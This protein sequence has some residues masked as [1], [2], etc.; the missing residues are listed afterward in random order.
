MNEGLWTCSW[1][2]PGTEAVSRKAQWDLVTGGMSFALLFCDDDGYVGRQSSKY[3]NEFFD[4]GVEW[5][6]MS[7]NDG[8]VAS[9]TAYALANIGKE[10]IL[11]SHSGN[12]FDV[13]LPSGNYKIRWYDPAKGT[14]SDWSSI[15]VNGGT[16]TFHKPDNSDWV[17]TIDADSLVDSDPPPAPTGLRV[18]S[19]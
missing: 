19:Y 15:N 4:N 1:G 3:L 17:L 12:S 13:E 16:A 11:Y 5:W 10:Y 18:V 2:S 8:V 14:Y 9:G 7:P 6:K